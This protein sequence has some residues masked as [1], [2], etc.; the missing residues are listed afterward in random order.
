MFEFN[1]HRRQRTAAEGDV[2][3][4]LDL[5]EL[6]LD[7]GGGDIVDLTWRPGL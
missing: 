5:A 1:A 6:L 7:H 3:D 2:A 4:A